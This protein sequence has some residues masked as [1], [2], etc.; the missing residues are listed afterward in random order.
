GNDTTTLAT[1]N[2]EPWLVREGDVLLVGSRLDTAWT[3]LP[4]SPAFV[5]FLDALVNRLARG[6][7]LV[8]EAEGVPGVQF[9]VRGTDTV[10]ATVYGP[11]PRESDLTPASADNV[12]RFLGAAVFEEPRFVAQRVFVVLAPTP[13]D[14]ERW[15]A[16]AHM[17]V[18]D[19][20]ALYP[21][22]EA[23]GAEEPHFEIAGER[24]E[25]LEA[26]LSGKIRVLVTTARAAA[27]RTGVP[28]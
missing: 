23:L 28:G 22:R 20:A 17:L 2:E 9:H 26:L 6:E 15:L 11:D 10:G 25:T 8:V 21:Q 3:A 5:P 14:A 1:V 24:I 27:E 4:A 19:A 16:D 13:S 12:R 7:A 18:G